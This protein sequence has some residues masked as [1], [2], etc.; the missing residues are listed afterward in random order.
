MNDLVIVSP[1]PAGFSRAH[2]FEIM[3]KNAGFNTEMAMVTRQS[4]R[5]HENAAAYLIGDVKNKNAIIID[6]I[7][8]TGKTVGDAAKLLK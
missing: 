1:D 5:A 6:D 7:I 4:K 2:H 3:L 8:D